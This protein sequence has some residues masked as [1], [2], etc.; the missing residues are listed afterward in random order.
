MRFLRATAKGRT[1][2]LEASVSNSSFTYKFLILAA[3]LDTNIRLPGLIEDLEREVLDIGL[4]LDI[5][6]FA[7]DETLGVEYTKIEIR[8]YCDKI[9]RR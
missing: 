1:L 3:V 2:A 9:V 8:R 6:E 7:A 4:H 5:I